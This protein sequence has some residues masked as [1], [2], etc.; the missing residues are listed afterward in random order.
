MTVDEFPEGFVWSEEEGRPVYRPSPPAEQEAQKKLDRAS[1][2]TGQR[3]GPEPDRE[4]EAEAWRLEAWLETHHFSLEA[5][6]EDDEESAEELRQI[7]GSLLAKAEQERDEWKQSYFGA[8][9]EYEAAEARERELREALERADDVL[10]DCYAKPMHKH[11]LLAVRVKVSAA[12]RTTQEDGVRKIA[13]VLPV[14]VGQWED[15][16]PGEKWPD[17]QE[18]GAA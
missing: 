15:E 10:A 1:L 9:A 16:H 18:D 11:R 14:P 2:V 4:Q 12:L 8:V 6:T 3:L 7:V 5:D 17:T 13:A